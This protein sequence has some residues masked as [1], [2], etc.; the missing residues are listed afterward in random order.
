MIAPEPHLRACLHVLYTAT[1]GARFQAWHAKD[2]NRSAALMEAVHTLPLLLTRWETFDEG[3]LRAYLARH[4]AGWGLPDSPQLLPEYLHAMGEPTTVI[5]IVNP[6][7]PFVSGVFAARD[8][9][10]RYFARVPVSQRGSLIPGPAFPFF[11]AEYRTGFHF[12]TRADAKRHLEELARRERVFDEEDCYVTMYPMRGEFWPR[13]R[14]QD[15]MGVLDHRHIGN[16]DLDRVTSG[17][18]DS[19]WEEEGE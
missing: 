17:G 10:D 7:R 5:G 3:M 11:V 15:E 6:G 19:L 14:G 9:A 12:L 13:V 18:F 4:D 8:A 2:A 1:V 16:E